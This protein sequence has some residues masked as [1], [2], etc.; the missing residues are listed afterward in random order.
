MWTNLIIL[1]LKTMPV[2]TL[3][4]DL[5]QTWQ[6]SQS[7]RLWE[8]LWP[9]DSLTTSTGDRFCQSYLHTTATPL[10]GVNLIAD[11]D[12]DHL[13][14][15]SGNLLVPWTPRSAQLQLGQARVCAPKDCAS[16]FCQ[17]GMLAKHCVNV[18]IQGSH[19]TERCC[20]STTGVDILNL[21]EFYVTV[22]FL[23]YDSN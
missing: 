7:N 18:L 17:A 5:C 11:K 22:N 2:S 14:A 13:L 23:T 10:V 3:G 20:A 9:S 19:Q 6:L 21:V 12:R 1:T 8:Q 4:Q 15:V 16:K